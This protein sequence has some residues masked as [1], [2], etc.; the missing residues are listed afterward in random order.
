VLAGAL[1]V[2][3]LL[4]CS[5][6]STQLAKEKAELEKK[7]ASLEE[8]KE[9]ALN[10]ILASEDQAGAYAPSLCRL[11]LCS[12]FTARKSFQTHLRQFA[13]AKQGPI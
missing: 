4:A 2:G 6:V 5:G 7:M 1:V 10:R 9:Q 12:L 13:S 8:K 11:R 3:A